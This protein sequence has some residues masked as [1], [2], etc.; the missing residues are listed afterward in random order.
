MVIKQNEREEH[1]STDAQKFST[2]SIPINGLKFWRKRTVETTLEAFQTRIII[3]KLN[4]TNTVR[5]IQASPSIRH[6]K[7]NGKRNKNKK[8]QYSSWNY[9]DWHHWLVTE[10]KR[11][12]IERWNIRHP[13]ELF[14]RVI[15]L[16]L[17]DQ[18]FLV[19][20]LV[21][22]FAT[23]SNFHFVNNIFLAQLLTD[24]NTISV[25]SGFLLI[26]HIELPFC[27]ILI[28]THLLIL[29]LP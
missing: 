16:R 25:I 12:K 20:C 28:L 5:Y 11:F 29:T 27:S 19:L 10:T 1:S 22:L 14:N 18:I 26:H 24:F 4:G 7:W 13:R 6:E 2:Y 23:F 8:L 15:L 3:E 9:E 21:L 17:M